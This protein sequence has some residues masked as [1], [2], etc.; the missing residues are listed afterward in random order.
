MKNCKKKLVPIKLELIT[1]QQQASYYFEKHFQCVP[2]ELIPN[3]YECILYPSDE[4]ML[5]GY[6][7]N[8][9]DHDDIF[10]LSKEEILNS[11]EFDIYKDE[12]YCQPAWGTVYKVDNFFVNSK[13]MDVDKLYKLGIGVMEHKTGDYLFIDGVG[14]D[15]YDYHWIPLFKQLGWIKYE[16]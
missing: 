3:S 4:V 9:S 14:Y 16:N 5:E 13:Y 6:L 10:K 1:E 11:E 2:L 7:E 15:F 12:N 8:L